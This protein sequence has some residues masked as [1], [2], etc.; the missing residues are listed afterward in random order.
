MR[1]TIKRK[2]S[3]EIIFNGEITDLHDANLLDANLHNANLENANLDN[4]YL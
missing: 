3:N 2:H 4:T 1:I